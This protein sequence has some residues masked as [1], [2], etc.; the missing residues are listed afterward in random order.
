MDLEMSGDGATLHLWQRIRPTSFTQAFTSLQMGELQRIP[1]ARAAAAAQA[2][3][4]Q[5]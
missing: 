1:L 4:A 5:P 2:C 3:A